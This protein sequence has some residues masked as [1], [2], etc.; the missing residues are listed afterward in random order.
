MAK[1]DLIPPKED[2]SDHAHTLARAGISLIPL[3]GGAA[4][5]IFNSIIAPPM[6]DDETNGWKRSPRRFKS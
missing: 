1:H 4:V 2:H 6:F 5:E 3:V